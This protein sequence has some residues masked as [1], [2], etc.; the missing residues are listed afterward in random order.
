MKNISLSHF[1]VCFLLVMFSHILSVYPAGKLF[2]NVIDYG[3]PRDGKSLGTR[4]IQA[5]L[6]DC[7]RKGG[8]TV[9]IPAG[10][11]VSGTIF[12]RSHVRLYLEAGAVLEGSKKLEDY[13]VTI[14]NV[15]SYTDNY[16]DKSLIYA[17]G[18]EDISISGPGT[19]D[20]NGASFELNG[21]Y[22]VRPYLIRVINCKKI[23]VTDVSIINSPMWV[24]HYLACDDINIRGLT[25][26]SRVNSNNDGIDIDG[27]SN[28]RISDCNII[29][30]DDAIVFKSTLDRPCTNATVTNC[31]LSSD[32]NALKFGTETNGGFQNIVVD[33]CTIYDTRLA[34][35]T[36]QMVDGGTLDRVTVSNI[37]M[38]NV[39]AAIFIRLGDRARPFK[40]EMKTPGPGKLTHVLISNIQGTGIGP[41]G[42]AIAGLQGHRAEDI[43]FSG[44]DLTFKGGG[45]RPAA[46]YEVPEVA[47][48]YPEHDMFGKLPAWGFWCRHC[49]GISFSDIRLKFEMND[50][51]PA[52]MFDDTE[53]LMLESINAQT[54]GTAPEIVFT[55]IN[56]AFLHSCVAPEKT[57]LFLDL[58]GS[59]N[60]YI[61]LLGNDL[62]GAGQA[63]SSGTGPTPFMEGNRIASVTNISE[64]RYT[65]CDVKYTDDREIRLSTPAGIKD[66]RIEIIKAIWGTE[67]LPDR[68][69]LK[70]TVDVKN[71]L[72]ANTSIFRVDKF[73]VPVNSLYG[74]DTEPVNDLAYLFTP[75]K[76]NNRLVLLNPGHS[77]TL[78]AQPEDDQR[79]EATILGLL[80]AGFD[81]LAVFMPHVSETGCDLNHCAVINTQIREGVQKP[82]S[83]LRFFLEPE[84]VCLNYLTRNLNYSDINMVGLSGGGWTTNLLAALDERISYSFN[85]AGSMP[86]YYRSGA[87]MGDIEQF[88][89][90]LYRDIAGYP[91]LYVLGAFGKGRKQVQILNRRDNCCFGQKQHDPDRRYDDDIHAFEATVKD[92]LR[93][94]GAAGHYYAVIDETAINH[95]I[96]SMALNEIIIR[97]LNAK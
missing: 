46:G 2:Y 19:I 96:S 26:N 20:G 69:D 55:N 11:F 5:A 23:Q 73:E 90:E 92:K 30:G 9:L 71:P 50:E 39:G 62:R 51:R 60:K 84:I 74:P 36:L 79:I 52:L 4:A 13:P 81:V 87:S 3:A 61:S 14:S 83:G 7:S 22:K 93:R 42:C 17:E 35:I 80:R 40:T 15:R 72:S 64:G 56:K 38:S 41:T 53:D 31:V 77:C 94:L 85:V 34:G 91:D 1:T 97:E 65:N 44:I 25:V 86:L 88:I 67:I 58:K 12:L 10:R 27:C 33:N 32:C 76:R 37:T 63:Y 47:A 28:V 57:K 21:P 66:K 70:I 48:A 16:T 24:Q 45:S 6:D 89:P 49:K 78:K 82:T 8:G 54:D 18:L 68:S 29:S 59:E 95:Q 75:V 43:R